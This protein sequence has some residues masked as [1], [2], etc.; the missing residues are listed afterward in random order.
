[1]GKPYFGEEVIMLYSPSHEWIL[2]TPGSL[3]SIGFV[4]ISAYARRELGEIVHIGFPEIGRDVKA[5]EE[6]AVLE[7]TKSAADL[8]S[9]VSGVIVEINERLKQDPSLMNHSSEELGWLY[10]IALT[11][12]EELSSLLDRIGYEALVN[13]YTS[14]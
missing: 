6:V 11:N 9:P 3:P 12:P 4:G 5:K 8:Y 7:S 2:V 14:P 13:G 1:L 10:K